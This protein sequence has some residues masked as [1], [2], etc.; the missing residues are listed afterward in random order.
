[1]TVKAAGKVAKKATVKKAAASV[2]KAKAVPSE[3]MSLIG[4][5]R[6]WPP[7]KILKRH[8]ASPCGEFTPE[9]SRLLIGVLFTP[10]GEHLKEITDNRTL[11]GVRSSLYAVNYYELSQTQLATYKGQIAS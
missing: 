5:N 1:M 9:K 2:T 8:I 4:V 7:T 11:E 10:H 3:V 6:V